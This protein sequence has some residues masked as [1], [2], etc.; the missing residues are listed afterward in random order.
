M[1]CEEC[2]FRILLPP[3][4][5]YTQKEYFAKIGVQKTCELQNVAWVMES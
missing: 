3:P 5:G 1:E 2:G 4:K